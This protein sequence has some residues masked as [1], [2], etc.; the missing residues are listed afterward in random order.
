[1]A[2]LLSYSPISLMPLILTALIL[3]GYFVLNWFLK[4]IITSLGHLK[5]VPPARHAQ[6]YKYFRVVL[7][8]LTAVMLLLAWGIDYRGLV[9][10]ASSILAM[11]AVALVA[12]WS[13]L[14]N[15]TAGVLIFFSFPVRIGDKMEIID[16]ASSVTGEIVEINLFQIILLD[17]DGKMI[18]Y[19]NNQLLQKAV[20]KLAKNEPP[21]VLS[22]AKRTRMKDRLKAE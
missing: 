17:D 20:R 6:V 22:P 16:G 11:L 7:I 4:R 2:D 18:S 12:Q 13:I 21:P 5:N 9:V 19:P 15:I 3:L 8:I 14:S 10:V 1:M